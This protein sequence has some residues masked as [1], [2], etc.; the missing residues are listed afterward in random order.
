MD[1]SKI[2]NKDKI[3]NNSSTNAFLSKKIKDI[4]DLLKI[5]ISEDEIKD[6]IKEK[7]YS[8]LSLDQRAILYAKLLYD[9]F[10]K[11]DIKDILGITNP[12]E[13]TRQLNRKNIERKAYLMLDSKY[14][15]Y[16]DPLSGKITWNFLENKNTQFGSTNTN[17]KIRDI[18]SM[19]IMQ[20][21]IP[22]FEPS[23]PY[24]SITVLIEELSSQAF[25]GPTGKKFHFWGKNITA[26]GTTAGYT[27][28]DFYEDCNEG[29][30]KF[31]QPIT[32]L[33]K[34]T[35][36]FGSPYETIP[37]PVINEA[38]VY[39]PAVIDDIYISPVYGMII[40]MLTFPDH[41]LSV[42]YYNNVLLAPVTINPNLA[43]P[44]T[45]FVFPGNVHPIIG[46][47]PSPFNLYQI[48]MAFIVEMNT[49]LATLSNGSS[50][51]S[52]F[53]NSFYIFTGLLDLVTY[54]KIVT[55]FYIVTQTVNALIEHSDAR[56]YSVFTS[57][58]TVPLYRF[59][60]N[61]EL[62][63]LDPAVNSLTMNK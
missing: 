40:E 52:L 55:L 11:I 25:I 26:S 27:L 59:F 51:V 14:A 16:I 28:I 42:N 22:L 1:D 6:M 8:G 39:S 58:M 46:G 7:K 34:I 56:A 48:S 43:Y 44:W 2:I 62:T 24:K 15:S 38:K 33:D 9:K 18:I 10:K 32:K 49:F 54:Q 31:R 19:K 41:R 47:V 3:I 23:V 13:L 60:V 63:Y 29:V 45:P 21:S 12:Y 17:G 36:S 57:D 4:L 61:L 35:L 37:I 53:K 20:C 30:Y 5:K 50:A